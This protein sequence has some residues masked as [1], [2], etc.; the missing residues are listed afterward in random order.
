MGH[1]DR[2]LSMTEDVV[3]DAS[4]QGLTKRTLGV[5]AHDKK[6][7]AEFCRLLKDH[8][9][10]PTAAELSFDQICL[11]VVPSQI[12]NESLGC[13]TSSMLR[14]NGQNPNFLCSHEV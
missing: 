1:K 4:G 10:Q 12:F 14:R 3:G 9:A 7:G 6:V 2:E 8:V 11:D 13:R 5:C